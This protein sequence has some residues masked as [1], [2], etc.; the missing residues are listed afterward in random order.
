MN[1]HEKVLAAD[2]VVMF[3]DTYEVLDWY[4]NESLG[5]DDNEGWYEL[6]MKGE[7]YYE[8]ITGSEM[9][10]WYEQGK[11]KLYKMVEL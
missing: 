11:I 7:Y 3:G 2:H 6:K 1:L 9:E 5:W 4:S 8:K 10:L